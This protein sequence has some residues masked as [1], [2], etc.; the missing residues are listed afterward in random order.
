MSD[1][2]KPIVHWCVFDDGEPACGAQMPEPPS[3]KPFSWPDHYP[4]VRRS[5]QGEPVSK[6]EEEHEVQ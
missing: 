5:E 1:Q 6:K 4:R 3:R 2:P